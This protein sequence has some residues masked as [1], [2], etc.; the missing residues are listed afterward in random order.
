VCGDKCDFEGSEKTNLRYI[1]RE[2][3]VWRER[4]AFF[5]TNDSAY[6]VIA[7]PDQVF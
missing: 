2:M 7:R 6:G 5:S 1:K 4:E 3:L